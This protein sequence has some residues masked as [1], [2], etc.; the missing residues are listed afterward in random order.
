MGGG[1]DSR[2]PSILRDVLCSPVSSHCPSEPTPSH[3]HSELTPSHCPSEP[4]S[5]HCHP[6]RSEGSFKVV[7]RTYSFDPEEAAQQ[8][9]AWVEELKPDLV[10]GE[11][12]G[13]LHAL[14]L[15][16]I[17]KILISPALNA[18]QYFEVLAWLTLIPGVTW[19]FDRIYKPREGD[20]QPLHFTFTILRKYRHHRRQAMKASRLHRIEPDVKTEHRNGNQD[21]AND[22]IHAFIGTRDHYLRTAIVSMSTYKK[23]FGATYTLY[24]GS[25][26]TE[27]EYIRSLVIPKIKE[28][29]G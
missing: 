28:L 2:I 18:P 21:R 1:A 7:C 22:L 3:C 14:R 26:F 5:S 9:A 11:S 29:L 15:S 27:E 20:R 13:C 4:I 17:P 24:D 6:E 23:H 25:H 19:I 10:I 12:L 16:G 8:I